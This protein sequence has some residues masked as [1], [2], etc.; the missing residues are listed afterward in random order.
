MHSLSVQLFVDL[1]QPAEAGLVPAGEAVVEVDQGVVLLHI[2]VQRQENVPDHNRLT[3][4]SQLDSHDAWAM[5]HTE[6]L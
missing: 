1:V 5:W 6:I 3:L 4:H 2:L